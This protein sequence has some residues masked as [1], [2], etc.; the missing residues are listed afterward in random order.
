VG[1][2][3]LVDVWERVAAPEQDDRRLGPAMGNAI[4]GETRLRRG[5]EVKLGGMDAMEPEQ[6]CQDA[7]GLDYPSGRRATQALQ[8]LLRSGP[9]VCFP[10]YPMNP[11]RVLGVCELA[12]DSPST[13]DSPF[14]FMADQRPNNLSRLMIAQGHALAVGLGAE[15]F[16]ED[17]ERAQ[18]Q[19]LGIWQGPFQPPSTWRQR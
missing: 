18:R 16:S 15:F 11:Q 9:A 2:V 14:D 19:R 1:R 12:K 5:V 7:D 4:D 6:T 3:F 13:P 8:T 10:M 17:Q